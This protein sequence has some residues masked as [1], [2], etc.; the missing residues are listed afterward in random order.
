MFRIIYLID[1]V[2]VPKRTFGKRR[3]WGEYA[4]AR[5]EVIEIRSGEASR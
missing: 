5:F 3:I 2:R 1:G 4:G